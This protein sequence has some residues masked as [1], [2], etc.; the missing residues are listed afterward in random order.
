VHDMSS[1][2]KRRFNF[3]T[4]HPIAD[5]A[6]EKALV[7]QQL[8]ERMADQVGATPMNDEVLDVLVSI[9][10]DLRTGTTQEGASVAVTNSVMSTAEAVN[11]AHAASLDAMYLGDGLVSASNIARQIRGVVFKDDPEDVRKIR[12]YVNNIAKPRAKG[13]K[14]WTDFFNTAKAEFN[15]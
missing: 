14:A 1:A 15:G 12:S 9:F 7:A 8:N 6:F 5:P 4:V 13:S 2:L 11:V 10:R 3:E